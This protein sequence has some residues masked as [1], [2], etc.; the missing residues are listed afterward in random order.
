MVA[1]LVPISIFW[2]FAAVYL[3][4]S[5]LRFEGGGGLTQTVGLLLHFVAYLVVY[6]VLRIALMGVAGPIFGGIVFPALVAS[7]L[8]PILGKLVFRLVGVRIVSTA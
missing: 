7:I 1:W 6:A 4:G 5:P 2:T 3:G 8:L